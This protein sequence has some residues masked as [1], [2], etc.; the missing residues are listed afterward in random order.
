VT[1]SDYF[2][3]AGTRPDG[4]TGRFTD[5]DEHAPI[6]A[7]PGVVLRAVAGTG[8]MLSHVTIASNSEAPVHTHD[9][10]QMGVVLSGNCDF[11]VDGEV[12][13]LG[14]GDVYVAGPGVP[15]GVRTGDEECVVLDVFAPPR[16]ALLDLLD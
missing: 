14:P 5:L 9:E 16:Q 15:H 7:A 4:S 13:R 6:E 11:E 8:V 10:E 1:A 12:R 2:G 3:A